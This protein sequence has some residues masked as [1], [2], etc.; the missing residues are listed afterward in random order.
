MTD[1]THLLLVLCV[2]FVLCAVGYAADVEVKE[3]DTGIKLATRTLEFVI[4]KKASKGLTTYAV[5]G[6]SATSFLDKKSGFRDPGF[7]LDIVDWVMESGSDEAYRDRLDPELVYQFNNSYHGR[8]PKR[9]IEGPQMC[10]RVPVVEPRVI[11]GKDFV[12]IATD[13]RYTKAAPGKKTGSLWQQ[14]LVFPAGQR[15]FISADKVTSVN[16]SE[17]LFLRLDMP[18]HIRH[19]GG[20]TF[21]EVYLSYR[22]G[23][24][25]SSEFTK[26]FPPDEKYRYVRGTTPTPERFIRAYRLRDPQTGKPGPWLAGMTLQPDVVSDAWCHQRGYVCMI[27]E[28]GGR[29]IKSGETFGAAFIVG[30]FD[31]IDEM[32]AVYDRYAGHTGLE[33]DEKGWRLTR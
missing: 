29:P 27:E 33:V 17:G 30:Y 18:G 5:S 26:D 6:V 21:S 9:C 1:M 32:N 23:M 14:R 8:I 19:K 25:P 2:L 20:D 28:I 13:H 11:R 31:S 3:D 24:I 16:D 12:A 15:Y 22:D 10:V 7:G 4:R